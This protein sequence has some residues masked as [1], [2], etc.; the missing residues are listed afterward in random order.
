[1]FGFH[2]VTP[3]MTAARFLVSLPLHNGKTLKEDLIPVTLL[4][5]L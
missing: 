5:L 3:A 4:L 2:G 1:M